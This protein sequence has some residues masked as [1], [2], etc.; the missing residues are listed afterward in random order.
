[1]KVST[2]GTP[3]KKQKS[4]KVKRGQEG[5][6]S[7]DLNLAQK[8]FTD[9]DLKEKLQKINALGEEIKDKPGLDKI[10]QYRQYVKEYLSFVLKHYYRMRQDYGVYSTQILTRVEIINIKIEELTND[11]M[12]QQKEN[13][14]LVNRI[15]E[16][17]GLLV[18]LYG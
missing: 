11:F 13:I 12:K 7:S 15:D 3:F 10:K 1:M 14:N 4:Y 8:E 6:F 9:R 5:D 18:D 16:I 17:A 2:I